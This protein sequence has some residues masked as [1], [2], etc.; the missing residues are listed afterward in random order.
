MKGKVIFQLVVK[1]LSSLCCTVVYVL[2]TVN[3]LYLILNKL[4]FI[5]SFTIV[6]FFTAMKW[7]CMF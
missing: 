5:L 3:K 1:A 7:T 6:L 2:P 4:Y